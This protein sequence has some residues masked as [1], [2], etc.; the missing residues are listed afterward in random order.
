M[1]DRVGQQLGNYRLVRLLGRGGFAEVYLGEHIRLKTQAAVKVLH[2]QLADRDAESFL[3]EAQTIAHLEH[4]H[5]VRVLDFDVKEG[6]PFLIMSYASEG[7]LRQRHPKGT[8]LAPHTILPYVKQVADALQYA[9]DQKLIHRD[10]KPENML[11]GRD[12]KI[13]VSDFGLATIVQSSRYQS[14]QEVAGTVTYMAPEQLQG[15]PRQASDQYAFGIV[16]YEWL[17]GSRPFQGSFGEVATQHILAA[18]PPLHEKV[19]TIS[20]AIEQVVLKALAKDPYQRFTDVLEFASAFEQACQPVLPPHPMTMHN[21]SALLPSQGITRTQSVSSEPTVPVNQFS[22]PPALYIP[23]DQSIPPSGSP[24]ILSTKPSLRKPGPA[25]RTVL[26]SITGLALAGAGITWLF[27]SGVPWLTSSGT[28]TGV[29]GNITSITGQVV[30]VNPSAHSVVV[31]VNGTAYMIG[32]LSDQDVTTLQSSVGRIWYF[33][34]TG[35]NGSYTIA[36]GTTPQEQDNSTPQVNGTPEN[37]SNQG[38]G[39]VGPGS[40]SFIGVV[41]SVNASGISVKMPNGDILSMSISTLTDHGNFG[42]GLPNNGQLVKVTT[43][44]NANGS[45]TAKMLDVVRSADQANPTILNTVDFQGVT[46]SAVGSNGV[47][48]FKVGNKSY[49]FTIGPTTQ[50][51]D[52]AIAQAIGSGQAVKVEVLFRGSPTVVMVA[53]GNS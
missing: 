4:P 7:T 28:G 1:V 41:Q 31:A 44:T 52:F 10:I 43:V 13:L 45:F 27:A 6:T 26:V 8:R 9:H 16:V 29:T 20:P 5:I 12:N 33:Q 48:N 24:N 42:T 21:Q 19:P 38:T 39:A 34:V 17:C 47:I 46:T 53:N 40:I 11:L 37:N 35:S 25:R 18:P 2:T 32:G 14:T 49:N 30:S 15:K 3:K 50:V 22:V 23:S 51:K 36:T